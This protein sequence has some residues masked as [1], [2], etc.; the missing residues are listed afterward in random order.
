[1]ACDPFFLTF[2]DDGMAWMGNLR[3]NVAVKLLTYTY[4]SQE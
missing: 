4:H 2:P 3:R 1:M